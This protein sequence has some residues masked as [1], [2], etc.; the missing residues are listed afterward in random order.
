MDLLEPGTALLVNRRG[1]HL[2][3]QLADHAADPHHLGRLL[4]HL[5]DR[6]LA[7]LLVVASG[8]LDGHALGADHNDLWLLLFCIHPVVHPSKSGGRCLRLAPRAAIRAAPHPSS[9]GPR[10]VPARSLPIP[11]CAGRSPP[12]PSLRC[13][14][15]AMRQ[16]LGFMSRSGDEQNLPDMLARLDHLVR[17][18]RVLHRQD[19][20]DHRPSP[21][22]LRRAARRA[23]GPRPRW[24]PSRRAA[25]TAA[26][27]RARSPAS[28]AARAGRARPRR[29]PA[30]RS[31]PDGRR[32]RGDS[33]LRAR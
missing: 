4:D 15:R 9:S 20:V 33:T 17:R 1:A 10:H 19:A 12:D 14:Q 5:G 2:F 25:G 31:P 21:S 23:R 6:T 11:L 32:L 3:E 16:P 30:A 29:R 24:R 8:T 22:P 28:T 26:W 7:G 27:W 13:G 18:G